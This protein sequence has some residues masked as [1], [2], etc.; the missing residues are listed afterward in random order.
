MSRQEAEP[1][2]KDVN[3]VEIA[4]HLQATEELEKPGVSP[5]WRQVRN[6]GFYEVQ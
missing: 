2:N 5:F 3:H 4:K 1:L 6:N